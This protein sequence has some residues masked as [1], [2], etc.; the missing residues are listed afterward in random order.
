MDPSGSSCSRCECSTHQ[1]S[2]HLRCRSDCSRRSVGR[3]FGCRFRSRRCDRRCSRQNPYCRDSYRPRTRRVRRS[4]GRSDHSGQRWSQ[5]PHKRFRKARSPPGS[6][7]P[8]RSEGS[9]WLLRRLALYRLARFRSAPRSIPNHQR[10][11]GRR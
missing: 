3:R 2:S 10:R 4:Y 6:Q 7:Y 5:N 9:R 11:M 8:T 1:R